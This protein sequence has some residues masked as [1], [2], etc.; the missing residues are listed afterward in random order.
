MASLRGL[1]P[2]VR[3]QARFGRRVIL[4]Q[5]HEMD[6]AYWFF[7]LPEQVFSVGGKL[8]SLQVDVEDTASTL[9]RCRWTEKLF[10][11][12]FIK[13]T[14]R[15]LPIARVRLLA[16][17]ARSIWIYDS[18]PCSCTIAMGNW[19]IPKSSRISPPTSC[20]QMKWPI[21]LPALKESNL[22]WCRCTMGRKPANGASCKG[23]APSW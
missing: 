8:S 4:S 3:F 6:Y 9:M 13:I 17:S 12:K 19:R 14:S 21:Y 20:F 23:I 16:T 1:P 15:I 5:I 10:Q 11:Y 18:N 2:D 7:G 22:R